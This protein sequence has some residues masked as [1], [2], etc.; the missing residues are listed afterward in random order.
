VSIGYDRARTAVHVRGSCVV[1]CD[2]PSVNESLMAR[3][4]G[5]R[6]ESDVRLDAEALHG[7]DAVV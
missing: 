3:L 5:D 7:L 4:S 1:A 2:H 6:L